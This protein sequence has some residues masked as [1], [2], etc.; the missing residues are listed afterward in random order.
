MPDTTPPDTTAPDTTEPATDGRRRRIRRPPTR[1]RA[2]PAADADTPTAL[3]NPVVTVTPST[4]LAHLQTVTVSGT[5]FTPNVNV[6]LAECH[7]TDSGDANDC[8]TTHTG[9]APTDASGAFSAPFTV[10][11]ILHTPNGDVDCAAAP[12]TCNIGA[13]KITDYDEHAGGRSRSTRTRRS[14]RR[15]R[16]S[17]A[18]SPTS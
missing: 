7:N 10:R 17:R 8:D 14:R 9:F 16:C 2:P 3:V 5:G 18:R 11:R 12:G 1:T 15:P 6:G 13:A 4:D